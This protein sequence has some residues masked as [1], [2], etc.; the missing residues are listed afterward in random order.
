MA[1]ALMMPD[2]SPAISTSVV[3]RKWVWSRAMGVMTDTTA[4]TTFVASHEPPM[5][6]STTAT[7]TGASANAA[8]AT[9]TST[10][11]NVI[12]GPPSAAEASSTISTRG[13]TSS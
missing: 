8:Y 1:S 10:S 6:T 12:R 9:A 4:S 5:P 7:S 2:F 11:K 3:P 13:I